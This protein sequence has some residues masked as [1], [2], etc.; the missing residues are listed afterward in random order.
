VIDPVSGSDPRRV[1]VVAY[2]FPPMGLSGVQRVVK[3]VKYLPRYGWLPTVLTVRPGGYYAFDE[4]LEA[5][6][7]DA[8]IPVHRSGSIDPNRLL[9]HGRPVAMPDEGRRDLLSR[10]SQA[11]FV[12]D[13]K[14]GWY[15]QAVRLGRSLLDH[16]PFDAILSSAPPYTAH[17][18]G[19]R[20]ASEAGLPLVLDYRDDWLGNPRHVYPTRAHRALNG[21]VER[22]ALRVAASVTTINPTIAASIMRR[23]PSSRRPEVIPQGFDPDDYPD[24]ATAPRDDRFSLIYAGVFYDAQRPDTFLDGLA[25]FLAARPKAR[26]HVV[27]RFLGLFPA[28]ARERIARLGLERVVEIGPYVTHREAM[29]QVA[30][31]SVA[32]LVVGRRPGAEQISTGKLYAYMGARRPILAL[33]PEGEV[34]REIEGYGA[35]LAVNPDDVP[36]IARAIGTLY[37]AWTEDRLP[38]PDERFVGRFDRRLLAGNL[39]RVLD[40]V[41]GAGDR[42]APTP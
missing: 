32:W 14:V 5:E 16:E 15:P 27:A 11:L 18:V 33:A 3:F 38:E 28:R 20:L 31:S 21:R 8:G 30:G 29:R 24:V 23:D 41:A 4:D 40:S 26:E 2:Y 10:I 17:L 7:R 36:A 25:T 37:D 22:W 6:I 19:A 35:A 13:N 9:G 1:L 34:R 39:A 12:P 42:H